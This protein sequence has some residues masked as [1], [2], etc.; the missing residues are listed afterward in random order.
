[1][2]GEVRRWTGKTCNLGENDGRD[3]RTEGN[4]RKEK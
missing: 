1:M 4:L 2:D 3:A